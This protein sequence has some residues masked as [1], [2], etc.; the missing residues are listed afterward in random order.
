MRFDPIGGST[1]GPHVG[2][3]DIVRP[4]T[5]LSQGTSRCGRPK[6]QFSWVYEEAGFFA[7][8]KRSVKK[9]LLQGSTAG[10][11]LSVKI[12]EPMMCVRGSLEFLGTRSDDALVTETAE[13][14]FSSA[15][16]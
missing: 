2:F 5:E 8:P 15:T 13:E 12:E 14:A 16:N 4:Q 6:K 10:D 3:D 7:E 9:R 11:C 1:L